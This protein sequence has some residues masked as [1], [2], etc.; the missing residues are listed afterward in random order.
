[1]GGEHVGGRDGHGPY[2]VQGKHG[3]PEL[4]A[5]LE[6]EHHHVATADAELLEI[7]GGTVALLAEVGKGE[8]DAL[9]LVIGPEQGQLVGLFLGPS[10]HHIVGEVEVVGH[11]KFQMLDVVFL[12][13]EGGLFQKSFYHK[14][15]L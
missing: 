11:D 14:R 6:D 5:A 9:P 13:G 3:Y 8:A 12:R 2:F 1:M 7:G 10:V 15:R 4:I